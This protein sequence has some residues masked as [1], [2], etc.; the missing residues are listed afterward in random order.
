MRPSRI[1]CTLCLCALTVP[2]LVLGNEAPDNK[3]DDRAKE[4]WIEVQRAALEDGRISVDFSVEGVLNQETL[5]VIQSGIPVKFRHRIEVLG[6]RKYWISRRNVLARSVVE[7]R[8]V[9]DAL[10]ARYELTRVTTL[11]KPQRK[12]GPPPYEEAT[13]TDNAK[14]MERWM[15]RG[16][17]V[18][19]Y[20]PKQELN[21][22]DL[23][24]V[25]ESSIGR[26]YVLWIFPKRRT[27][28]IMA[29]VTR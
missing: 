27:V 17:H 11:K 19:L 29:Q 7:T 13:V 9:Y 16:Q 12:K 1:F 6:P 15:V 10:T 20:D 14:E 5:E 26:D 18:V 2:W 25:I 3:N 28:H 8:V 21:G 4:P 22:D 23:R 24:V